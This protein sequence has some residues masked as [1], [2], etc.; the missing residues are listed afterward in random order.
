M[1]CQTDLGGTIDPSIVTDVDGSS[2]LLFKNDG[3][4]C[5]LTTSLWSQELTPDGLDVVGEPTKLIDADQAWEGDLIEAPS[6]VDRRRHLLALLLGQRLGHRR[7]TRSGY[8][9]CESITGPCTKADGPWMTSTV[10]AK[11]PGGQEFFAKDGLVWMVYHGW[12]RGQ[13]GYPQGERRLYLD[14]V[15]VVD[16]TPVRVGEETARSLVGSRS[17]WRWSWSSAGRGRRGPAPAV[18]PSKPPHEPPDARR[19]GPA[20]SE[21][22]PGRRPVPSA[23]VRRADVAARR[24]GRGAGPARATLRRTAGRRSV[25]AGRPASASRASPPTFL[26]ASGRRRVRDHGRVRATRSTATIPFGAFAPWIPRDD[27]ARRPTACSCCGRSWPR[28]DRRATSACVVAVDDAHLLDEGSAALVLHLVD[29]PAGLG[30]GHGPLRRAVPGRGH[31]PLE[32]EPRRARRPAAALARTRRRRCSRRCSDGAARPGRARADLV[33]D[34]GPAAV[35]ARG[36]AGRASTRACWSRSLGSVAV[37]RVRWPAATACSS[38]STTAWPTPTTTN[39]GWSSWWPSAS[40]CPLAAR[41]PSSGLRPL[42]RPPSS[43]AGSSR[44]TS[45]RCDRRGRRAVRPLAHPL[46]G[47]VV[48]AQVPTAGPGTTARR[49]SPPRS[50]SGGSSRDPILVAEWAL[51]S[52]VPLEPADAVAAARRALALAEWSLAE[53]LSV[54]GGEPVATPA[55]VLTRAIA[56]APQVRWDA[57]RGRPRQRGPWRRSAIDVR[58]AG[59]G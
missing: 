44:S 11:G 15:E 10:F 38:S 25:V 53:R 54:R 21:P 30:R 58:T 22:V 5:N 43:S 13:I 8:A 4:C 56:L 20:R 18:G 55:A 40:P 12:E 36:G 34:P 35:P 39:A 16:G 57:G 1:V 7:T 26:D 23:H 48:R 46:Y 37:A 47:E 24:P 6:M 28:P 41:R 52:D 33:A 17:A 32:G 51:E 3:N 42:R 31:R 50:R 14:I 29:R 2:W 19:R 27:G 9:R 49:W 59:G 45:R